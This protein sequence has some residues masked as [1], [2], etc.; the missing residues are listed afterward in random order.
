M[1]LEARGCGSSG[2]VARGAS[3][4]LSASGGDVMVDAPTLLRTGGVPLLD[5]DRL[6]LRLYK[7][8]NETDNA[9]IYDFS[10]KCTIFSDFLH[11]YAFLA[12]F[13]GHEF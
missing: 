13:L 11:H 5:R 7:Q 4:V 8:I 1:G 3:L 6:L 12:C 2:V 10:T 9:V